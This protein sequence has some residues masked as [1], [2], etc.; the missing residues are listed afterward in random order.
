MGRNSLAPRFAFIASLLFGAAV[1]AP[2]EAQTTTDKP[3]Q[4][5]PVL[6]GALSLACPF[7]PLMFVAL[8]S[9]QKLEDS[10]VGMRAA[11][12]VT[13]GLGFALA[14]TTFG[15][16]ATTPGTCGKDCKGA[17]TGAILGT[18]LSTLG[19]SA[20]IWMTV[21]SPKKKH[22]ALV[23]PLLLPSERATAVGVGVTG[24]MF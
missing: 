24:A 10:W 2:A 14:G 16:E 7:V 6:T 9:E 11:L 15:L 8:M 12:Y 4:G 23:H 17:Y 13:S 20:A 5:A 3:R 18:V 19:M 22:R 21:T 1:S